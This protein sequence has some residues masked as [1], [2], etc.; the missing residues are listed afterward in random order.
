MLAYLWL[1][2]L[3]GCSLKYAEICITL[4]HRRG[5]LS[6][7]MVA[8]QE[9]SPLLGSVYALFCLPVALLG[10]GNLTQVQVLSQ[11]LHSVA[12][13]SL[14][15]I[16]VCLAALLA[17]LI[18]GGIQRIGR[19][20]SVALP[21]VGGLYIALCRECWAYARYCSPPFYAR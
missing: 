7:A 8:L 16:G 17:L 14:P 20:A 2:A 21:T 3:T 10:M 6:G 4:K 1:G 18:A 9:K 13:L 5:N 11:T 15:V 12:G 19:V